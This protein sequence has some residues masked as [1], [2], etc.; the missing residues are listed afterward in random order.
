MNNSWNKIIYKIW[1]PVYDKIFNSGKFL[2]AREE[3]FKE[4]IF[5]E[6]S[7]VL[8]VGVGTGVDLE[9]VN[10]S[11]ITIT[12][13]DFS[14]D[15]LK[16]AKEKFKNYPIDFFEMDAQNMTFND[17]SYDYVVASLIL[18]VVP[19]A[20]RGFDEMIRVLK[21]GGQLIIFDKFV[22]KGKKISF[23]KKTARPIIAF[24]G[25]DIGLSFEKLLQR[26]AKSLQVQDNQPALFKGM[27]RRIIINRLK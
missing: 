11:R 20:E 4:V 7:K 26:H 10:C 5:K 2:K 22:P 13:I 9:Q 21:I 8:F 14:P 16:K 3:M 17:E 18:S 15:M 12:A 25:T 23:L 19:K 6:N 27:Y 1:S 24:L